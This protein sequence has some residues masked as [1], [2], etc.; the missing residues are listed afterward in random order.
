[1][2]DFDDFEM[3]NDCLLLT[4]DPYKM[5][6]GLTITQPLSDAETEMRQALTTDYVEEFL[7]EDGIS[8]GILR[9]K[10]D[11]LIEKT[12]NGIYDEEVIVARGQAPKDGDEGYYTYNI[13]LED[14]RAKPK[15]NDDGSVDYFSTLSLA[16][17]EEN[18]V[19][20]VYHPPTSG[21]FGYTVYAE[22]LQP[23]R[24]RDQKMLRGKGFKMVEEGREV[25]YVATITGRIFRDE[26]KINIETI[27]VVKGDLDIG[28]GNITFEGDVEI[29]GD[30]RSGLSID[31]TGDIFVHG[32]VG[33]CVLKAGKSIT[34]RGGLQGKG[35]SEIT[36]GTDIA[37]SFVERCIVNAG[38]SLYADSVMDSEVVVRDKVI[39]SSKRGQ[40][41]GGRIL[42]SQSIQAKKVGNESGIKTELSIGVPDSY[43]R[44]VQELRTNKIKV[45]KELELLKTRLREMETM[46][47]GERDANT[48][49]FRMKCMRV[50][51]IKDAELKQICEELEEREAEME[52]SKREGRIEIMGLVH[53]GTQVHI[54]GDALAVKEEVY[55]ASYR[56]SIHGVVQEGL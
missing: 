19:F 26:E 46:V 31:A 49:A 24:G 6:A 8:A 53:S 20:A 30:V 29:K 3:D 38:G 51:V 50:K 36:A 42:A 23:K 22:P 2:P 37:C 39:V 28:E 15:L 27:Y 16:M 52:T 7:R 11:E 44:R 47:D 41:V 34:I 35:R 4:I 40:V 33:S 9:D 10:I 43:L 5:W 32:H 1:M 17:V 55:R 21:T 48:E 13:P 18:Q 25:Y 54:W 12:K 45:G 56:G 14:T